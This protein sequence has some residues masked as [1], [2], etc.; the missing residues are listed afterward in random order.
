MIASEKQILLALIVQESN[1]I[2]IITKVITDE[3][4]AA[5]ADLQQAREASNC[6]S[7]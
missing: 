7:G 5:Q 2:T 4:K 6:K 1:V 3:D